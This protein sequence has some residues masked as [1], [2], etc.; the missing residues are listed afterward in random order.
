[1]PNRRRIGIVSGWKIHQNLISGKEGGGGGD[2][3]NGGVENYPKF[4]IL[5]SIQNESMS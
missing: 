5:S 2:E 4:K 3:K 1:M